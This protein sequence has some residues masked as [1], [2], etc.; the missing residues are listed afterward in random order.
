M[1]SMKVITELDQDVELIKNC[2]IPQIVKKD[3][4]RL[5]F[6]GEFVK[7][8]WEPES[9]FNLMERAAEYDFSSDIET[10]GLSAESTQ[11][12]L[13]HF[14]EIENYL[15]E[16]EYGAWDLAHPS[17]RYFRCIQA[18]RRGRREP[19]NHICV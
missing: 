16:K 2:S 8:D 7:E 15:L 10:L 1:S 11:E 9:L 19:C 4:E 5:I 12:I 17:S 13:Q 6:W 18:L 14:E 3:L